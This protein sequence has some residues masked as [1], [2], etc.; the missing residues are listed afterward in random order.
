MFKEIKYF[1]FLSIIT[2]FIILIVK[3]YFS[4]ENKKNSFRSLND[5]DKKIK[6]FAEKLPVLED[7]TKN[8]IEYVERSNTEKKKKFNFWKLL[9]NNE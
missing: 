1:I 8:I 9:E 7:D 3:Y 2:F 4:D 5:I 6:I